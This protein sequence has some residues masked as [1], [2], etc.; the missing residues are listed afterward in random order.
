MCFS[1]AGKKFL[2]IAISTHIKPTRVQ[3]IVMDAVGWVINS[4]HY[5][6]YTAFVFSWY[7]YHIKSM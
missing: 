6:V 3:N 4:E 1:R 2:K 5:N 7:T